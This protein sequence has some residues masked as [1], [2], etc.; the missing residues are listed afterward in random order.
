MCKVSLIVTVYNLENYIEKC[1][2]SI[3]TQTFSEYEVL[4]VDDGSTDNSRE[5]IESLIK[6]DSRFVYIYKDNGG[7]ASARNLGLEKANGE[8]ICFIDG[9]D[10]LESNYLL[11]LY[12]GV[13]SKNVS[14]SICGIK[15][16]YATHETYNEITDSIVKQ[17]RY[18]ALWNKMIKKELFNKFG[19]KFV[20]NIQYEDL[21][22]GTEI[23]LA[24]ESFAV[25]NKPLYNYVQHENS[26][27][28]ENTDSI[29]DIYHVCNEIESFAKKNEEFE[30]N[31]TVEFVNIYHVLIGTCYRASFHKAFSRKIIKEIYKYVNDKYPNWNDNE[32][33][34]ELPFSFKFFLKLLKLRMFGCVWLGLT[35]FKNKLSI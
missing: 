24:S 29:F 3:M 12:N 33:L 18:P 2:K 20:E 7:V 32:F 30:K 13:S 4:L 8:Y 5:I 1:I 25:V 17:C 19:L 28:R 16:K 21:L 10:Y 14:F 31:S 35:L 23:Y 9:D 26:R 34:K 22:L 11:E 27:I 15:R 6:S